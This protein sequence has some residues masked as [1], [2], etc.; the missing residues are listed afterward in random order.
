MAMKLFRLTA[1]VFSSSFKL[2]TL[3]GHCFSIKCTHAVYACDLTNQSKYSKLVSE[4]MKRIKNLRFVGLSTRCWP[5][6]YQNIAPNIAKTCSFLLKGA[7]KLVILQNSSKTSLY[8][9]NWGT[10]KSLILH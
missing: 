6:K 8:N 1:Y 3:A 4:G 9:H 7:Q 5:A 2:V 10:D